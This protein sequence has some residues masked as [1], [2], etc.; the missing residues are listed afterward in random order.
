MIH[1]GIVAHHSRSD[2][3][4]ELADKVS[5]NFLS[6]DFRGDGC[7]ANHLV[8][9]KMHSAEPAEWNVNLEDDAIPVP[10]FREQLAAALAVAPAPIVSLYLGTGYI[11]DRDVKP[12]LEKA[13]VMDASWLV[14]N[15]GVLHAVG[16]AVRGDL[17]ESMLSAL[18]GNCHQAIDRSLSLW[19]RRAGHRVAYTLPSLVDHRDDVSLVTPNRRRAA[20]KAWKVGGRNQWNPTLIRMV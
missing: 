10:D 1:V 14:T 7:R 2:F 16:L 3:A 17:L 15:G 20:R 13:A 11:Y 18:Q 9:W 4:S 19:A 12:L 8:A 5:A 6:V